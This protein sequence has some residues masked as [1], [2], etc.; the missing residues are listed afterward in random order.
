[1]KVIPQ[2]RPERTQLSTLIE[3]F[4]AAMLTTHDDHGALVGRPMTPLEMDA[5]GALWFFTDAHS[6]KAQHLHSANLSFSDSDNA[7]YVSISG[8]GELHFDR[9]RIEALW[10]P[11]AKPWF[12][13]GSKSE[14]LA[15]LKFIPATAEYWDAPNS[16]MVRMFAMAAS[17]IASKP[18]MLGEH[19]SLTNL[20]PSSS[21][22]VASE[23]LL[24]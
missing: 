20:S 17:I 12:P 14:N 16:K 8:H 18:M 10:T 3:R 9:E 22:K 21:R 15:L 2:A 6:E 5:S 13:N 23:S 19:D 24:D 4:S 11:F 7:T 1:M